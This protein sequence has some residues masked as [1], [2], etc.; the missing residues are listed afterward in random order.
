[1]KRILL[2]LSSF[3]VLVIGLAAS[4]YSYT[5]PNRTTAQTVW[6][7]GPVLGEVCTFSSGMW[8]YVVEKSY[9][10][11][12]PGDP[13]TSEYPDY[14]YACTSGRNGNRVYENGCY[15]TTQIVNL[16]PATISGTTSCAQPGSNGWCKGG[17]NLNLSSTEPVPGWSITGIESSAGMLCA[18]PSCAWSFSQG[19]TALNFWALSSHGDT[20]LASS[21]WMLS[22]IQLHPPSPT[23]AAHPQTRQAG[24]ARM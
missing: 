8:H 20:S 2:V 16:P 21:A 1:M 10:C 9:D 22:L 15:Q 7:G 23:L 17:A 19:N 6:A 5:G 14:F 3:A 13:W 4:S 24:T 18:S 11:G 12:T